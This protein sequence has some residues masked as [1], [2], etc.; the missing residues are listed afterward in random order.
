MMNKDLLALYGMK[1]NPFI[2]E[3]PVEALH[4]YPKLKEF[5]WEESFNDRLKDP[6]LQK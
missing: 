6:T 4:V 2:Q 3:V 5:F 1:F